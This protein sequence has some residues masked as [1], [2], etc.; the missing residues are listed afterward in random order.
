MIDIRVVDSPHSP[1]FE[2]ER[3]RQTDEV[4][5]AGNRW[6]PERAW[7]DIV[8]SARVAREA[9]TQADITSKAGNPKKIKT[10]MINQISIGCSPFLQV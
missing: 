8:S 9:P 3:D 4:A 10:K 6:I 5:C 1:A 2:S 7:T